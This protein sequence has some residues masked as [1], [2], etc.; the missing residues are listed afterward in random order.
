[1][2]LKRTKRRFVFS[3]IYIR[4][5]RL[6]QLALLSPVVGSGGHSFQDV[7]ILLELDDFARLLQVRGAK[8]VRKWGIRTPLHAAAL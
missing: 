8:L 6:Q 3:C 5:C 1:M 7:I 4:R 2:F